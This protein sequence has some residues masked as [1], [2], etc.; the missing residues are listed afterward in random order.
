MVTCL[1]ILDVVLQAEGLELA[2]PGHGKHCI[3][4]HGTS[5]LHATAY[6]RG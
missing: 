2:E 3:C 1:V 6:T 5:N 4:V